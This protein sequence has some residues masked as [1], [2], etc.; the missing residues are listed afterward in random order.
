MVGLVVELCSFWQIH[1]HKNVVPKKK[2]NVVPFP[3]QLTAAIVTLNAR[4]G[5]KSLLRKHVLPL[6]WHWTKLY[7]NW[8]WPTL[9]VNYFILGFEC[10]NVFHIWLI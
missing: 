4:G 2:K 5:L 8:I 3:G 6:Q 10:I 9:N 1:G 7:S